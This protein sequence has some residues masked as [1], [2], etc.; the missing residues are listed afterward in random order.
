MVD[1]Q[2]LSRFLNSPG[3]R[4]EV[5]KRAKG[6]TRQRINLSGLRE[7]P[8]PL[9]PLGEQ[10]RIAAILD[11]GDRLRRLRRGAIERLDALAQS[12]FEAILGD[13]VRN[14]KGW[15]EDRI[16]ADVAD[17][18]SGVTKG[19]KLNGKDTR[20][21][22]YLAVAN[23]QD[24]RLSLSNIKMIEASEQEIERYR[25]QPDDLLLTEG[26]D[27]DKLGRGAL[28]TGEIA[29]A[30]HQ[31]HIFRVRLRSSDVHPV[32]LNW[33]IGSRRG[34]QYFLRAAKQTTGIASINMGQLK[35]FPLL[36]PPADVQNRFAKAIHAIEQAKV[37]HSLHLR[38]LDALF[39]SL[40]HRAFLGEL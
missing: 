6:S 2:Y 18:G 20:L 3:G 27:P 25:L 39:T 7:I 19:R 30:I 29:D 22:P 23:V 26:G 31:N 17:I 33:L 16:L 37:E 9:P 5:A 34:K 24:R 14:P 13:P 40:Q 1:H 21:V 15:A 12:T 10:R 38:H 11:Q 8:V 35:K 32:F 4:A 36:V 28:W